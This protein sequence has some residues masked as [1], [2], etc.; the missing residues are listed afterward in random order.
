MR[1]GPVRS[2]L[3]PL[4]AATTLAGL[5]G[6][7]GCGPTAST[8][9]HHRTIDPA[10]PLG[11]GPTL[12]DL[13]Q[14]RRTV[15]HWDDQR[16]AGQVMVGRFLGTDPRAAGTVVRRLHLAGVCVTAD[17]TVD[18]AQVRATTKAVSDAVAAD[19]R[20]FP[21]VI[22]VD[23]EGGPVEHLRGIATEFPAFAAAGEAV[24]RGGAAGRRTVTEAARATALEL[25]SLG[26]TWV[27]APVADVTI[28]EDDP[29]IGSRSADEDPAVAAKAV[30]AALAGYADA[31]IV[32]TVKHFPG[33]GSVTADSHYSLPVQRHSRAWVRRH[34]LP[35]FESAIKAHAPVVMMAHLAARSLTG[36]GRPTSMSPHTYRLL[37]GLGFDG[38][39][40]TDS[41]GMGAVMGDRS[42][43]VEAL[44]AGVDLV[45]MPADTWKAHRE[46]VAALRDRSLSRTRVREAAAKV[47]ALQRWSARRAAAVP[48]PDDVTGLAQRASRALGEASP[49]Y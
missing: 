13:R 41:L 4:L 47:V 34:D 3:V 7:T 18:A 44:R 46:V 12:G 10:T 17:N 42:P 21:A 26:F 38:V 11:W 31:A 29:T 6:V 22:G 49:T 35:P 33:H 15:A 1:R 32:P 37:A 40:I 20:D 43:S 16:L 36:D 14:A 19:G 48:V 2:L 25:R 8:T 28:G 9:E 30:V 5:A 23:E 45:L 24:A 27:F 39:S